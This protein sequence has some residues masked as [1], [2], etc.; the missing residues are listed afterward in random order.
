RGRI[1]LLTLDAMTAF[2]GHW[3]I[4]RADLIGTR[5]DAASFTAIRIVSGAITL[6]LLVR[7]RGGARQGGSWPSA[8]WLFA[9][10]IGFSYAYLTLSAGAGA[11]LLFGAVQATMIVYGLARGELFR[12]VQLPGLA[13]AFAGL[14]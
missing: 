7:I 14:A 9:Y 12:A 5:I 10:A 2:A 4:C 1:V 13:A 11:L 6:W 3:L 8:F